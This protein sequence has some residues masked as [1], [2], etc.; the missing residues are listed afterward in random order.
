MR[1][2]VNLHT[3]FV[4]ISE[5]HEGWSQMDCW[6]CGSQVPRDVHYCPNCAASLSGLE[7]TLTRRPAKLLG[8]LAVLG[9]LTAAVLAGVLLYQVRGRLLQAGGA[10]AL[11]Q[12]TTPTRAV[13]TRAPTATALPVTVVVTYT[14]PATPHSA[15]TATKAAT[16][17]ATP[18][19]A[20]PQATA[21]P[22]PPRKHVVQRGDTLDAIARKY[23]VTAQG[24][25]DANGLQLSSIL[26]VGQELTIP[27]AGS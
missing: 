14:P 17:T 22:N 4:S 21:K 7:K 25:A 6:N 24:I 3:V 10:E 5:G 26:Q 15:A 19:L 20:P 8:T 12:T 16:A 9:W 13:A 1:R 18:S 27:D 11:A 2:T 23:G